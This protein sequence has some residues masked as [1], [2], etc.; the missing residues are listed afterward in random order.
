[1]N[2]S[3]TWNLGG[4]PLTYRAGALPSELQPVA[5]FY[6]VAGPL[7]AGLG[8]YHGYR[9]DGTVISALLW[10]LAGGAFPIIVP[11]IA[12]AQGFGK[13]AGKRWP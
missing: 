13:S 2:P 8:A 4:Q 5:T 10:A 1:M 3:N 11:A 9:R 12:L 7:S 6:A